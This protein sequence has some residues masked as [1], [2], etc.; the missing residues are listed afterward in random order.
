LPKG[1]LVKILTRN[2]NKFEEAK[3][4]LN[5]YGIDAIQVPVQVCEIQSENLFEI[6]IFRLKCAL[7]H[8]PPPIATEDSGLFIDA[9]NGFPGPFSSYVFKTI[10]CDGVL[11]LMQG[12][13]N[14]DAHF[15]SVVAF[16]DRDL[17]VHLFHGVV[18]GVISEIA[19]GSYGFGFDP[20][21]CPKEKPQLT[22]AEM[23]REEKNKI[24]HRS[25]AFRKLA[26][27]L[28]ASET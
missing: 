15:E 19:R 20:I 12:M 5:E 17:K 6:A 18:N 2:R 16:A 8:I 3:L 24:S 9:L 28:S 23:T 21:F 1:I 26:E 7:K 22:F 10:G 11:R 27:F 4:V 13:V 14:R 25:R